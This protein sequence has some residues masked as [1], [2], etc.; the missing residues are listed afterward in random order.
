M[1][2]N[3]LEANRLELITRC[4]QKAANRNAPKV[5]SEAIDHGVPLFLQQLVDAL[6]IAGSAPPTSAAAGDPAPATT[7]IGRSAAMHG[8]ELLRS[9]YNTDQVVHGYGDVCQAV[10]ELA[11]E[12]QAKIETAEFRI[13][14]GALDNA[15]ADA[16]TAFGSAQQLSMDDRSEDQDVRLVS[17]A[18]EQRKLADVA[19]HAFFSIRTGTVGPSGATGALLVHALEQLRALADRIQ[20]E[21]KGS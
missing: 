12:R 15:I 13:L 19:I 1:L 9:G 16:V 2:V 6:R 17:L 10:T 7:A 5:V 14:N 20:A 3:F 11:I 18:E 21:A 8:A 4:K